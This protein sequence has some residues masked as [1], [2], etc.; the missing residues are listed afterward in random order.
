M[1]SVMVSRFRNRLDSSIP[2]VNPAGKARPTGSDTLDDSL[3]EGIAAGD[4]LSMRALYA[5]HNARIYRFVL[6]L[7]MTRGFPRKW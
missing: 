1:G 6:R 2:C 7:T 4:A 5:R 3:M